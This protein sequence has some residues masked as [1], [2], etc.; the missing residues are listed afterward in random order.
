MSIY[1]GIIVPI[2]E[3]FE[4]IALRETGTKDLSKL[5]EEIPL[6]DY[7]D[8][9]ED[10]KRNKCIKWLKNKKYVKYLKYNLFNDIFYSPYATDIEDVG[11]F[12][13]ESYNNGIYILWMC[14]GIEISS[15]YP[16]YRDLNEYK[17]IET[18][19]HSKQVEFDIKDL[20]LTNYEPCT[21]LLPYKNMV[22]DYGIVKKYHLPNNYVPKYRK[23]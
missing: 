22:G 4:A 7:E 20:G 8:G 10:Y 15:K 21:F 12:K 13:F 16:N 23:L 9:E 1:Y 5:C 17:E 6:L 14:I 2:K 11:Y 18:L 19:S 3:F